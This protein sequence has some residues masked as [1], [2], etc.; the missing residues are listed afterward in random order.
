MGREWAGMNLLDKPVYY[1]GDVEIDPSRRL[2]KR[3]GQEFHLQLQTFQVLVYLIEHRNRFVT[4]DELIENVW[5]V[6]AVTDNALVQ[7]IVDIR[8]A[9][10]DTPRQPRF[11]KTLPKLGYH[12]IAEVEERTPKAVES[13]EAQSVD[14]A[15]EP[16]TARELPITGQTPVSHAPFTSRPFN[17]TKS[18]LFLAAALVVLIAAGAGL[19]WK[20][21]KSASPQVEVMLPVVEGKRTLAV[22]YFHNQSGS[23][24]LDW[25]REG[26]ADMFITDLSRATKLVVLSR[27]QLQLLLARVGHRSSEDIGLDVALDV[28][29][30]SRAEVILMGNFAKAGD[31]I[32]IDAQLH[33]ARNG[34]LLAAERLIVDNQNQILTQIDLLSIKLA[35]HLGAAPAQNEKVHLAAA[36]TNNLEAYRYY[37][38]GVEKAQALQNA[39]AIGFLEKAVR[40]DP[41]F[42]MAHARI[43]YAYAVTWDQVDKGK[44]YLERAFKLVDRLT[45]KDKLNINA[46][47]A[48]ANRDYQTAVGIFRKL[49]A[50]YPTDVEAYW[51]LG[52]LLQGEG[53]HDEALEISKQGLV[54]DPDAKDLYNLSGL[55]YSELGRH[56]EA[57]VA[58]Q[59]YL[60]LAPS[61]PNAH[62]SLGLSYQWAGRYV[63][64]I[65]KYNQALAL[66]PDFDIA[67]VHLGNLYFQQGRYREAIEQYRRYI[68][69][70][71][72][73]AERAR[74][75]SCVTYV[76]LKK[77][78]A[79][80]AAQAA[81]QDIGYDKLGVWNRLV[82]AVAGNKQ[83]AIANLEK[84][85]I[86]ESPA[87]NRGARYSLR[88]SNYFRGYLDLKKGRSAEAIESFKEAVRHR[89]VAWHIDPFEDCLANAYLELGH[90]DDAI[91]EYQRILRLNPNYPLVHYHLA[92]AYERKG[93]HTQAR[94]EYLKF[95]EV[96]KQAD[97]D[98][99]EIVAAKKAVGGS[100]GV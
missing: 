65:E 36:M 20:F 61:E 33:N 18:H 93:D 31:Q 43:G 6:T 98:I 10:G 90:L 84:E 50:E 30:R 74:G 96:W 41:Q 2:V 68:Q 87:T 67:T 25:M 21:R 59:R 81:K 69:I 60:A 28:A 58:H 62:D 52:R 76:H 82:I 46:W 26:L 13:K 12:F 3:N 7:C 34:Q 38:L 9:L 22:M 42:A 17:F 45:E 27:Q 63:E 4:K 11:V 66:D 8:K 39:E 89:P 64:A 53:R 35:S 88:I 79:Q 29:R 14:A 40:L 83:V 72:S 15:P 100:S 24:E 23:D 1:T 94:N 71:P 54:I 51:R 80:L 5:Q 73:V 78:N 57:I 44:P 97:A 19:V 70:A 85:L 75:G 37:S 16:A 47:Y 91:S 86:S 95:L 48:L 55:I 56:E 32:R 77:G 92:Q 49:I 99:P